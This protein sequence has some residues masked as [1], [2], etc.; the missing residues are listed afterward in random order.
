MKELS[1]RISGITRSGARKWRSVAR[2][3]PSAAT[4]WAWLLAGIAAVYGV[5]LV[6]PRIAA[7]FSARPRAVIH[8]EVFSGKRVVL[9]RDVS[10][11]MKEP[12]VEDNLKKQ[13]ENLKAAGMTLY[14]TPGA[15]GFGVSSANTSNNLLRQIEDATREHPDLDT[16]YA[17]SDFELTRDAYWQSDPAGYERL[18]RLLAERGVRLYL[19]T[20]KFRPPEELAQIARGSG[21]SLIQ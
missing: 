6:L 12:A 21:G 7:I 13:V 4:T 16:I 11:S 14:E 15:Y 10:G 19:G 17:F 8:G 5:G 20:V 2:P 9:V 18:A 1:F 3:S